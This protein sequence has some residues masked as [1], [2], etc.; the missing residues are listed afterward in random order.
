MTR[1]AN[2]YSA[3]CWYKPRHD[4]SFEVK[5]YEI[6]EG[7]GGV[8]KSYKFNTPISVEQHI[9]KME[10]VILNAWQLYNKSYIFVCLTN[11][12]ESKKDGGTV[13]NSNFVV[14]L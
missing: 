14:N 2:N 1:R 8:F 5:I 6:I 13:I 4:D 10:T 9:T 3:I 12:T 11:K 7:K